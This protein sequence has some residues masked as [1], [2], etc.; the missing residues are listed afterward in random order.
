[1]L[2]CAQ[3][4]CVAQPAEDVDDSAF[5][6]DGAGQPDGFFR[7]GDRTSHG[8]LQTNKMR[9]VGFSAIDWIRKQRVS[10]L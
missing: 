6:T 10:E 9:A 3:P 4:S 1:M 2:G 7:Q 8:F 5:Q